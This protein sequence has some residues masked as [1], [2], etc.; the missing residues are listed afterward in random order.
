RRELPAPRWG[1]SSSR[2]GSPRLKPWA[3]FPGPVRGQNGRPNLLF[4]SY[5]M[6][7]KSRRPLRIDRY[8]QLVR[9]FPLV[10][11]TTEAELDRAIAVIDNLLEKDRTAEEEA[12][13]DVLSTIVEVYEEREY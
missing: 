12:Y 9:Q 11:I 2:D 5:Y 4:G 7:T 1:A 3:K 8:V 6:A 13:L 10:H